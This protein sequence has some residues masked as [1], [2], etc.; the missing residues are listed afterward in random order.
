MLT[1]LANHTLCTLEEIPII[2]SSALAWYKDSE[3][4]ERFGPS[5]VIDGDYDTFYSARNVEYG[6]NFL[7]LYLSGLNTIFKVNITNRLDEHHLGN[8][9]RINNTAL[10]VYHRDERG[11][12]REVKLCGKITGNINSGNSCADCRVQHS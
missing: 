7:N 1:L 12:E 10:Y 11:Y 9:E 4:A 6:D 5:N 8:R 3:E 2:S